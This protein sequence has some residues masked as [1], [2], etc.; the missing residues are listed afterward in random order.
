MVQSVFIKEVTGPIKNLTT[1]TPNIITTVEFATAKNANDVQA[2][3][4]LKSGE[5][6]DYY[7]LQPGILVTLTSNTE[8]NVVF[9]RNLDLTPLKFENNEFSVIPGATNLSYTEFTPLSGERAMINEKPYTFASLQYVDKNGLLNKIIGYTMKSGENTIFNGELLQFKPKGVSILFDGAGRDPFKLVKLVGDS[10]GVKSLQTS[11]FGG[12]AVGLV[13]Q[14]LY[15]RFHTIQLPQVI[16]FFGGKRFVAIVTIPAMA[17]LA[18]AFLIVWPW[19]GIGLNAFGTAIGSVPGGAESLIFGYVERALIPFGLHHVF[20]APLWYSSA[21]G[22]LNTQ[23]AEFLRDHPG[24]TQGADLKNLINIVAEHPDKYQGDSTTALSLLSF[25]H[26]TLSY[27]SKDGKTVT[28]PLFEFLA[29]ELKFKIGRFADGKFSIMMFGLPAAAAA[30][31]LAAPKENRKVALGTVVPA[32]FTSFITGVTEPIEFT[33]LFLSPFL[34]WG[35]H[36]IMAAFS[37]MFANLAGVHVPMAFSGGVLDLVSYG[38]I[39]FAKGTNF[40]WVLVVGLAYAPIYLA[41]FYFYIKWKDLATPGRGGN[42]KLFTKADYLASKNETATASAGVDPKALAIVM[43]Y[44]GLDNITAFNNCASRLRYDVKDAS[45][46]SE[47]KLKAAGAFG[48]KVEGNNH[49]QAIFGPAA[50]QLNA[51]I[52]SQREAIAKYLASEQKTEELEVKAEVAMMEDEKSPLLEPVKVQTVARGEL[53]KLEDVKDEVFSS[54][55]LG[56]GF[57]V[58]FDA[59]ETGNVYSPVDG[60]VTMV[61]PSKHAV[62]IETAEGVQ[63]LL[64]IG[65]NTVELNGEGFDMLVEV[66]QMVKAGDLVA[67]VDLKVLEAKGLVS[68]VICIVLR[69]GAYKDFTIT[70]N[71]TNIDS[72]TELI[73]EVK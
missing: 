44:G 23:L 43:A 7:K 5:V 32:A 47:E 8:G 28:L 38:I 9:T 69:E 3:V 51:K 2:I 53:I 15:N 40:Y 65:I 1:P 67:K 17:L 13:I 29:K 21:G 19:I 11:V 64:H 71:K 49:V 39:P 34:F 63:I 25:Q 18:F 60:R 70:S 68:D 45:L 37:F 48:V 72:T 57:A 10:L 55:A 24:I 62:G 36:S 50:E 6:V 73:G 16:S 27:T 35:F 4:G 58:K 14:Y 54:K 46:V 52:K 66:D 26:D 61:F 12:I 22:D 33:F 42:T 20:Y 41:V 30:M 31:V 59:S 56:E